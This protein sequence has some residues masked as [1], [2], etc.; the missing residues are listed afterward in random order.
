MDSRGGSGGGEAR[1]IPPP[2]RFPESDLG[3]RV[4]EGKVA[5][6]IICLGFYSLPCALA[7]LIASALGTG[8]ILRG[9]SLSLQCYTPEIIPPT[10]THTLI[11][12][13]IHQELITLDGDTGEGRTGGWR[14]QTLMS[15][16]R[17]SQCHLHYLLPALDAAS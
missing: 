14:S 4:Q 16:H 3:E 12:T 11:H 5:R 15:T 6:V 13:A 2:S 9:M 10:H 8:G 17:S 1:G 7:V